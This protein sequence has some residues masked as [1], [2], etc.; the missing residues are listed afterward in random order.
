MC[1]NKTELCSYHKNHCRSERANPY[2]NARTPAHLAHETPSDRK[3]FKKSML[4]HISNIAK[5]NKRFHANI[6][7][8]FIRWDIKLSGKQMNGKTATEKKNFG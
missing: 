8:I 1:F 4:M 3:S 2:I 5:G 7:F 6:I